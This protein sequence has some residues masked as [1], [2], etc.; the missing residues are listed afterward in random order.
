MNL[1][2]FG[3]NTVIYAIG[4]VGLRAASFLLI[5]LYAYSLS[6]SDYGLLAILLITVQVMLIFMNMG[7][8]TTLLRFTK[9][10]ED[11]NQIKYLLGTTTFASFIAGVIVTCISFLFLLPFFRGVLHTEDVHKF[12]ILTCSAALAQS[13]TAHIMSYYRARNEAVKF[14]ITGISAAVLLFIA[15]FILLYIFNM[16]IT[17]ALIAYT[18]TYIVILLFVSFDVFSKTGIGISVSLM[19]KLFRFGFPLVFSMSGQ[20]IMGGASIYF[21]SYFVGLEV[22][23]IYSLGY[24]LAQI[25]VIT[26]I[27]PFSL[28][29]QPF[30]FADVHNS[31]IKEKIS[32]L[33]T[34]LVLAITFMSLCILLGSRILLPLI[35][36][37]EYSS[38]YLVILLLLPGMAFIGMQYFGET[39]LSAVQ[40]THIIGFTVSICAIF[41]VILNCTLIP[42][43]GWYGAVIACNVSFI[44]SGSALSFVG[45]RKFPVPIEWKRICIAGGI[46]I[47]F[48]VLVFIVRD[49]NL[50][51]FSVVALSAA[52]GSIL[53]LSSFRFFY[54][55]EKV[56]IKNLILRLR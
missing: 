22:V 21:L 27:L 4:N 19:P 50:I 46:I 1:K 41:S 14:M 31:D 8:A 53:I 47:S 54:N 29:F 43:L 44:L 16:G 28:A 42:V 48:F 34:Y 23:A 7:M 26:I 10:Y 49:I 38:A 17:G 12:I 56:A 13:L 39:L 32:R 3:K 2:L 25:L 24:K 55:N 33:L 30:V 36:P 52:L 11:N 20:F 18:A 9:E 35:A 37:P 6:V 5:P 51:L 40:K 15:N 45:I